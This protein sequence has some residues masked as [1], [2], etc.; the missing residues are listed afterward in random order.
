[1]EK[2]QSATT[3]N[4]NQNTQMEQFRTHFKEANTKLHKFQWNPQ[5]Q[6]K[7]G[8]PKNTWCRVLKYDL[9]KIGKTCSETKLIAKDRDLGRI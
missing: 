9:K 5:G 7:V 3:K 4:N 2:D 1:M 8:R 6:Q